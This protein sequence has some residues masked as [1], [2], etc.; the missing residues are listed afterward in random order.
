[1]KKFIALACAL[2]CWSGVSA[3]GETWLTREADRTLSIKDGPSLAFTHYT[4]E[5]SVQGPSFDGGTAPVRVFVGCDEAISPQLDLTL[6]IPLVA[7]GFQ[8]SVEDVRGKMYRFNMS[9]MLSGGPA[10]PVVLHEESLFAISAEDRPLSVTIG[11]QVVFNGVEMSGN[12]IRAALTHLS[13][14]APSLSLIVGH[15][16][17]WRRALYSGRFALGGLGPVFRS[18]IADNCPGLGALSGER[19]QPKTVSETQTRSVKWYE[20]ES[21]RFTAAQRTA[22]ET[23]AKEVLEGARVV[24]CTY[25]T[26]SGRVRTYEFWKHVVPDG[27]AELVRL[28]GRLDSR[29]AQLGKM[30]VNRCPA[31]AELAALVRGGRWP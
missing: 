30:A 7:T 27:V 10:R 12:D 9:V 18:H 15:S 8:G 5:G 6:F 19:R 25:P 13:S 17:K 20:F 28:S 2:F 11:R 24:A 26:D 29:G 21:T 16:P 4:I 14:D 23:R 22:F 3:S 1:M 31:T